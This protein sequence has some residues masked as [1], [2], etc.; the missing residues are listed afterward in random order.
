MVCIDD[1]VSKTI[2]CH[3]TFFNQECYESHKKWMCAAEMFCPK[4]KMLDK[5]DG[6]HVCYRPLC[7]FCGVRHLPA[8]GRRNCY[9][10]PL[11]PVKDTPYRLV[12]FDAEST[13]KGSNKYEPDPI[14]QEYF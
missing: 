11:K 5:N 12:T 4:C 8:P 1:P 9:V 13:L 10:T 14:M 3:K 7:M 2:G 6:Q